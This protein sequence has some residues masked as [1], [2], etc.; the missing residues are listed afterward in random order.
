MLFCIFG[1]KFCSKTD[2]ILW[3]Y[4]GLHFNTDSKDIYNVFMVPINTIHGQKWSFW[5]FMIYKDQIKM[6]S[7]TPML[8]IPG[9]SFKNVAIQ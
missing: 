5:S 8:G 3:F 7:Y 9:I 4:W 6:T 2:N 1:H